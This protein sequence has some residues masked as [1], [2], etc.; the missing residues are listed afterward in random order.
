MET[1]STLIIAFVVLISILILLMA[2][3]NKK[4]RKKLE[5]QFNEESKK[6]K[7]HIGPRI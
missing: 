3:K 5:R 4:D 1:Q 6:T 7:K 2:I